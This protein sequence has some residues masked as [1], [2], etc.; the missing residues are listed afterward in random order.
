[1]VLN[2][3]KTP[4]EDFIQRR[5]KDSLAPPDAQALATPGQRLLALRKAAGYSSAA[6]FARNAET[7]VALYQRQESDRITISRHAAEALATLLGTTAGYILFGEITSITKVAVVGLIG[8][9]GRVLPRREEIKEMVEA[10]AHATGSTMALKVSNGDLFP[11]YRG[12]DLMYFDEYGL[13]V[14]L[15][16][17]VVDGRECVVETR[18]DGMFV[19]WLTLSGTSGRATLIKGNGRGQPDLPVVR[20]TPVL[21]VLRAQNRM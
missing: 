18:H 19:G 7:H 12:G 3:L 17:G 21:S 1:M 20:A 8:L 14:K 16:A 5:Y 11:A 10:P 4:S 2:A 9:D 15:N 13:Q 6:A